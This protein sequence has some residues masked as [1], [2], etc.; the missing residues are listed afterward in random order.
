MLREMLVSSG[1]DLIESVKNGEDAIEA[2]SRQKPDIVLCDYYLGEGKDGQQVLEE[3][4]EHD[5]LPYSSIFILITAENTLSMVMGV[6]EFEPD[7]YLT[8][9]FTRDVLQTRL[10]RLQQKKTNFAVIAR[11]VERREYTKAAQLCDETSLEH[12]RYRPDL[13]RIKGDA[14]RR[15]GD[16][17]ACEILYKNVLQEREL[18]WAQLGLAQA[19][20]A[21]QK[22]KECRS[23]LLHAISMKENFVAAYDLLA[24][25]QKALGDVE[26]SEQILCKAV[27]LSPKNLR[28]QQALGDIALD[29]G[30]LELAEKAFRSAVREGKNSLFG[31]PENYAGLARVHIQG[32]DAVKADQALRRMQNNYVH[33]NGPVQLQ[34]AVV[35]ADVQHQ[36]GDEVASQEATR[37]AAGLMSQHGD[38]LSRN[39]L[40]NLA[41]TC[42]AHGDTELGSSLIQKVVRANHED[43]DMLDKAQALFTKAGM[44]EKGASLIAD[45][46][47]AVVKL[48]N[49]AVKLVRDGELKQAVSML[50]QAAQAM[51]E[52]STI[53][54]N[55]VQCLLQ[56]MKTEGANWRILRQAQ[57]LLAGISGVASGEA[58]YQ[59][60][61][62]LSQEMEQ[63]LSAAA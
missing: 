2:M 8:K 17:Q 51:P 62:K 9:P 29:N 56:L 18:P 54:L 42:M 30:N 27:E 4:R 59:G 3:A 31:G 55:A 44:A 39:E 19:L 6:V 36:L 50:L 49:D 52:N 13:L 21:Q 46:R 32:G 5:F 63:Q 34:M 23:V 45:E 33:A 61:I 38:S 37:K 12:P 60:L 15:A 26:A 11:A 24:L 22:L 16:H 20:H 7:A 41:E 57:D 58:R 28:R 43:Q 47:T 53:N 35:T 10:R 1:A 40:M 48:N 25:V 14:L